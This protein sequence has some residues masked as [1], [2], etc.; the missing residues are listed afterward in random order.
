MAEVAMFPQEIKITMVE[1]LVEASEEEDTNMQRKEVISWR[2]TMTNSSKNSSRDL[3]QAASDWPFT[4][5]S[6]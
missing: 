2:T 1:I 6:N 5:K 4:T 3:K